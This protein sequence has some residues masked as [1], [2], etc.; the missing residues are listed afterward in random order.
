MYYLVEG[1]PGGSGSKRIR[2][3]CRRPGLIP[4]PGRSPGEGNDNDSS[5]LAWRIPWREE[6]GRLQS[7]ELDR[8]EQCS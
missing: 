2:L 6:P 1:F 4:G 3:Q 8:T 7:I 5:F